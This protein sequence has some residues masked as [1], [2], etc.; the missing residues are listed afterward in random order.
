MKDSHLHT[1][2]VQEV[3]RGRRTVKKF[4]DQ[5]LTVEKI[6]ELLDTAVWA[7]NHKLREPWRFIVF[8]GEGRSK[9]YDAISAELG[10]DH[11]FAGVK[12]IPA[13]IL[14]VMKEDPRQVIWDEDYAA[15]SALIQNFMLAA[16]SE[17]VGT[18]WVTKPFLY[19]P[20]FREY[21]GIK[22][23]ERVVGMIYAGYPDVVPKPQQRTPASE[24][25]TVF[26]S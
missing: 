5:P 8:S 22:P 11:K 2:T 1:E 10:E 15:V 3:I 18:F 4:T 25:M 14:F 23:G 6:T 9:L 19:A 21:L 26:D 24:K 17:G 13:E 12:E 7:P 20:K 16:W